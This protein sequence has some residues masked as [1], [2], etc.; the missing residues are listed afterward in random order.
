M[1]KIMIKSDRE[2]E[3]LNGIINLDMIWQVNKLDDIYEEKILV[4]AIENLKSLHHMKSQLVCITDEI[5]VDSL[6]IKPILELDGREIL[7]LYD[8]IEQHLEEANRILTGI[9]VPYDDE[10][11]VSTVLFTNNTP[12]YNVYKTDLMFLCEW[13]EQIKEMV[14]E[15]MLS[16]EYEE[17]SRI[18][19]IEYLGFEEDDE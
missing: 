4:E 15:Y 14:V 1:I 17:Y 11:V 6:G 2:Y 8:S 13:K 16:D 9:S 18:G 19:I 5:L 3:L 12:V 7:L 10:N